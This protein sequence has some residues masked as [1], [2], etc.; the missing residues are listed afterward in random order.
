MLWFIAAAAFVDMIGYWLHRWAHRPSSPL[1]RPH[2][3]HHLVSYPPKSFTS[4]RY[5]GSGSDSLVIWF[6]PF[7]AVFVLLVLAFSLP[8]LP[9]LLGGGVV[10]VANSLMHDLSHVEGSIAYRVAPGLC[11]RHRTHHRKMGRNFGVLSSTWD[12]LFRTFLSASASRTMRR[13]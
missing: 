2:M 10:A 11:E 4:Q 12:R 5:L 13:P 3:T 9:I 6:A 8:A 7:G 1:H